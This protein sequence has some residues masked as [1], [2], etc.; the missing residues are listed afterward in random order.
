MTRK[1]PIPGVDEAA[2]AAL[3]GQ[4]PTR[5]PRTAAPP[6]QDNA[7]LPLGDKEIRGLQSVASAAA[8]G[9]SRRRAPGRGLAVCAM[10][11][12]LLALII[13]AT[14][15]MPPPARTWLAQT[16]GDWRI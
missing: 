1:H 6:T 3:A 15:V 10:L 7:P 4:F 12:A 5:S 2:L 8:G 13:A 11:L 9:A 16:L 14:S